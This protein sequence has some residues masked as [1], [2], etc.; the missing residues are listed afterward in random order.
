MS[1]RS[2][3]ALSLTSNVAMAID[4]FREIEGLVDEEHRSKISNWRIALEM[5]HRDALFA[6]RMPARRSTRK[7][8]KR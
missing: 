3:R 8:V 5:A 4:D 2:S 7:A 1:K 6:L